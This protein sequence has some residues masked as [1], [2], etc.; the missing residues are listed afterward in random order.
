L[1]HIFVLTIVGGC[2]AILLL[3]LL[4]AVPLLFQ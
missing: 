1:I 4:L 2:G 3:I